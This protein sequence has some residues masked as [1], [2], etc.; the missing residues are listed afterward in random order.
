MSEN[1]KPSVN[2]R[3]STLYTSVCPPC[4][5]RAPCRPRQ[6]SDPNI[7]TNLAALLAIS[8]HLTSSSLP[9]L[10]GSN[11]TRPQSTPLFSLFSW[12]KTP[13][14]LRTWRT[15]REAFSWDGSGTAQNSREPTVLQNVTSH[16][17]VGTA[18]FPQYPLQLLAGH[19][20][21]I[22]SPPLSRSQWSCSQVSPCTSTLP[23]IH[24][25]AFPR[26]SLSVTPGN[27]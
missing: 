24:G 2:T 9:T 13:L 6:R 21:H 4:C 11:G 15:L 27:A 12:C 18:H 20:P 10:H 1:T 23:R 19:S 14:P 5:A 3:L 17:T 7:A 22:S 26:F 25:C 16:G 8:D